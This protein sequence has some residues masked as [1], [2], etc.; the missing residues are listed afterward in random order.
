[1]FLAATLH[2]TAGHVKNSDLQVAIDMFIDSQS[3]IGASISSGKPWN[4][5][6]GIKGLRLENW[7]GTF[8][9]PMSAGALDLI[10]TK[11]GFS[12]NA[13]IT[14]ICGGGTF[15]WQRQPAA[16]LVSLKVKTLMFCFL[17]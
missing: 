10:P 16:F 17:I 3:G 15:Y 4:E 1:M 14:N 9:M 5:P 6:F 12:A 8:A 7:S 13:C 11:I 2:L